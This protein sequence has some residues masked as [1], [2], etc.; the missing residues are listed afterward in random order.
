[1]LNIDQLKYDYYVK[2]FYNEIDGIYCDC[3]NYR[4]RRTKKILLYKNNINIGYHS[5]D[6]SLILPEYNY[7]NDKKLFISYSQLFRKI[8]NLNLL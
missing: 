1:M 4:F 5:K 7:I 2:S 6:N 8:F 3:L